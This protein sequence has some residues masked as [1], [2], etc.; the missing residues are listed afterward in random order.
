[1]ENNGINTSNKVNYDLWIHPDLAIQL[2]QWI[3]PIF[4]LQVSKW[5]REL[6]NGSDLGS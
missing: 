3:S 6:F 5:I 4:A 2:A 1:M